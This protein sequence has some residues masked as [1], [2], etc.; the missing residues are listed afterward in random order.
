[1]RDRMAVEQD[2]SQNE[3]REI[4]SDQTRQVHRDPPSCEVYHWKPA[5]TAKHTH[6]PHALSLL[7]GL[8]DSALG[9]AP[10]VRGYDYG[11]AAAPLAA[12]TTG[13]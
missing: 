3:W 12:A 7:D 1:M 10:L 9:A 11:R 2:R 13:L 6:V 4:Q 5:D 8:G